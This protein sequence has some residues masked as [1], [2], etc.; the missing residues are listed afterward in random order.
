MKI[1][2]HWRRSADPL[3]VMYLDVLVETA[4]GWRMTSFQA[5]PV[6]FDLSRVLR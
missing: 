6:L 1:T 3:P 2:Y 4:E 5:G